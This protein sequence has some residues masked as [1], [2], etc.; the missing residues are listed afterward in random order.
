MLI[1]GGDRIIEPGT[2]FLSGPLKSEKMKSLLTMMNDLTSGL[3]KY[4][5][6]TAK[7]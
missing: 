1:T 3:W 2:S 5:G 7:Y 4:V 6:G